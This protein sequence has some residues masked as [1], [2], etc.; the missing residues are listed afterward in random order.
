MFQVQREIRSV[1]D[2]DVFLEE[3]STIVEQNHVSDKSLISFQCI[4][5]N[6][7]DE[8]IEYIKLVPEV[9]EVVKGTKEDQ[10]LILT[11]SSNFSKF[12][13]LD[14]KMIQQPLEVT[15]F[16]IP[17]CLDIYE[18]NLKDMKLLNDSEKADLK[19]IK[20]LVS[21]E[22]LSEYQEGMLVFV[23]LTYDYLKFLGYYN[24]CE[25]D[26]KTS[27]GSIVTLPERITLMDYE[28]L[29]G[30]TRTSDG[31]IIVNPLNCHPSG[32]VALLVEVDYITYALGC[33]TSLKARSVINLMSRFFNSFLRYNAMINY[34]NMMKKI[35]MDKNEYK[36]A[37]LAE[38]ALVTHT[39][40]QIVEANA[41]LEEEM[42][43]N[44]PICAQDFKHARIGCV[45]IYHYH[46]GPSRLGVRMR[47]TEQRDINVNNR[48]TLRQSVAKLKSMVKPF[49]TTAAIFYGGINVI[50]TRTLFNKVFP[51]KRLVL[52]NKK[53]LLTKIQNEFVPLISSSFAVG[54]LFDGKKKNKIVFA[55]DHIINSLP[56]AEYCRSLL[57]KKSV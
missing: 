32:D 38:R 1:E 30:K 37:L 20:K 5:A 56:D 12:D 50:R 27:L 4:P 29:F 49:E 34:Q 55:N 21:N 24:R 51:T 42:K 48:R 45:E 19:L 16:N 35:I 3:D 57:K 18:K 47:Y 7:T 52:R 33:C 39:E 23:V 2:D 22:R 44:K 15:K 14:W 53:E 43:V 36:Q 13:G 8:A 31:N 40:R 54:M 6:K 26:P 25:L 9:V 17:S 28:D 11:K 41:K 46:K 10:I